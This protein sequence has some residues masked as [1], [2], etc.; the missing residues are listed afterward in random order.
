[1]AGALEDAKRRA[2]EAAIAELPPAG[3]IGLGTGSTAAFFVEALAARVRSG[4]RYVGVP[5]SNASRALAAARGIPL[6]EDEGPWT[7]D[8]TVDGADEVSD[9]LDLIKGGGGAHTREK[10]VNAAS[11]RNVIVVD[12]SKRSSR[13]GE[14]RAVPV[15]IVRFGHR[16]TV[17]RLAAFGTATLRMNGDGAEL[18]TDGG[19]LVVDVATGSV[20]DPVALE[21]ALRSVVGVLETGLFVARADVVL[22]AGGDGAV[23][24]LERPARPSP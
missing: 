22:V 13:L 1:M 12:A 2:A 9:S 17:R 16:E 4:A 11:R 19:N 18:V 5:T 23:E 15:E 8:V 24:R 7:V 20:D 6:L 21:R 14:K 3:V 10:I